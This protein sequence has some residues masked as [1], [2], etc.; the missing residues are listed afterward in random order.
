MSMQ[1]NIASCMMLIGV[2]PTQLI[3]V[4]I[5]R[6]VV[7]PCAGGPV[8]FSGSGFHTRQFAIHRLLPLRDNHPLLELPAPLEWARLVGLVVRFPPLELVPLNGNSGEYG[9]GSVALLLLLFPLLTL[10]FFETSH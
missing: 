3:F 1:A 10:Q 5:L 4:V 9:A 7:W 2:V 6:D 8:F